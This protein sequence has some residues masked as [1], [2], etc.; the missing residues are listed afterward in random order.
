MWSGEEPPAGAVKNAYD[1]LTE[2]MSKDFDIDINLVICHGKRELVPEMDFEK[3]YIFAM[4]APEGLE[5]ERDKHKELVIG[6]KRWKMDGGQADYLKVIGEMPESMSVVNDEAG[7]PLAIIHDAS[8]YFLNDFPHCKNQEQLN[9]SLATFRYVI[10]EATKTD[11]LF[12]ALKAGAEEKGKRA[13]EHALSRQFKDRLKKEESALTSAQGLYEKYTVNLTDA[14]RKI[15]A[16]QAIISAIKENIEHVPKALQKKW[17]SVKKLEGSRMYESISFQRNCV[18]GI[19][20]PIYFEYGGKWYKFGKYEV[21]LSF[22]GN[23]KINSLFRER[24][25][26]QDHPHITGGNPCWGNMNGEPQKRIAESEFDVAFVEIY[27][28][29]NHYSQEGGPYANISNWPT[30]NKEDVDKIMAEYEGKFKNTEE[31]Q[32]EKQEMTVA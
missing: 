27:S 10:D 7:T 2:P 6:G 32:E 14:Q 12:R 15:I 17:D 4:M 5:V 16:T 20:T 1:E 29:L 8:L 23:I 28:F 31:P 26:A 30:F 25:I 11:E 3:F 21:V 18:K 19:T 24:G 22:D 13:L 9:R